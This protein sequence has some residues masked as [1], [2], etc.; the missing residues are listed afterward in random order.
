MSASESR[1]VAIWASH[2]ARARLWFRLFL[3]TVAGLGLS[4]IT[5]IRVW[6][7]PREVIRIGCDG[8]PQVVTLDSAAY[9][10]PNE[11]EI[12]GFATEFDFRGAAWRRVGTNTTEPGMNRHFVA[13]P[14]ASLPSSR[15]ARAA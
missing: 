8:I 10:E 15:S 1:F 12:R 11:R 2:E 3:L 13:K 5:T 14:C 9:S 6:T 4:L 7:R